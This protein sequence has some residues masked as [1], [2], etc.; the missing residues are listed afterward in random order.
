M[1]INRS[2]PV[3]IVWKLSIENSNF[4]IFEQFQVSRVNFFLIT[5]KYQKLSWKFVNLLIN[6]HNNLLSSKHFFLFNVGIFVGNFLSTF[7][8]LAMKKKTFKQF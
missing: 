7:L 4:T 3:K 1:T 6:A 5:T 8:M 2:K